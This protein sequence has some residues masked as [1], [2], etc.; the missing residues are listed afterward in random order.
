MKIV[1]VGC[2]LIGRKRALALDQDDILAA[3]CDVN[4]DAARNFGEEFNCPYFSSYKKLF[5]EIEFDA[6]IIAVVKR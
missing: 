1:I 2:G 3:C 4:P 6:V 5:E